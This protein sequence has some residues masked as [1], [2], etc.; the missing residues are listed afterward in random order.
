MSWLHT[1]LKAYGFPAKCLHAKVQQLVTAIGDNP[2]SL[3][4]H[5]TV[6]AEDQKIMRDLL[7]GPYVFD[8]QGNLIPGA[9]VSAYTNDSKYWTF[10]L[11][12]G[13]CWSN[14]EPLTAYDFIYSWQRLADPQTASPKAGILQDMKIEN[15]DDIIA[16]KRPSS[17]LG[18]IASGPSTLHISLTQSLGFIT[19]FLGDSALLPVHP[20]TVKKYGDLWT[21]P[22]NWV[23]NGAYCLKQQVVNDKVVLTRN[24]NYWD[25]KT[26]IIDQVIYLLL[27]GESEIAHY[28]RGM[29][30]ISRELS[31]TRGNQLLPQFPEELRWLKTTTVSGYLIN[32]KAK[33]FRDSRVRQALNLAIDRDKLLQALRITG[34]DTAYNFLPNGLGGLPAFQPPWQ[35]WSFEQR[36]KIARDLLQ[37][38]GFNE[39]KPLRFTLLCHNNEASQQMAA[40]VSALWKVLLGAQVTLDQ[41]EQKTHIE[42]KQNSQYQMASVNYFTTKNEAYDLLMLFYSKSCYNQSNY[43]NLQFDHYLEKVVTSAQ[44]YERHIWYH[45]AEA[46]LAEEAPIIPIS[47]PHYA[48]LVKPYIGGL[49]PENQSGFFYTKNLYIRKHPQ[50]PKV[51][52]K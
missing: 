46:L 18:I 39:K 9:F 32:T 38:A 33:P 27:E 15:I 28:K 24:S 52:R 29:L 31:S 11:R 6:S 3:D 21:L 51:A 43:N 14:G 49:T 48:R 44:D 41:Q 16:G 26:T 42:R 19:K 40:A 45:R 7:E 1:L 10:S 22:A 47:H 5:K 17:D 36:L 50:A 37:E 2:C 25:N 20:A 35:F 23:G 13:L 4:P 30:D 12:P 8:K 34:Q